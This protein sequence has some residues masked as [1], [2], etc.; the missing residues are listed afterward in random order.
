MEVSKIWEL[1]YHLAKMLRIKSDCIFVFMTQ[2][3]ELQQNNLL[4]TLLFTIN[5]C[6][7]PVS[8]THLDVYKRQCSQTHQ[9]FV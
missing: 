5:R 2:G 3:I 8:Y 6:A 7:D 1:W 4:G 9:E